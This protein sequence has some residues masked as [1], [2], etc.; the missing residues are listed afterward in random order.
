MSV[1]EINYTLSENGITPSTIQD[2]GIQGDHN[3]KLVIFT[4][5]KSFYEKIKDK[6]YTYY[7]DLYNGEGSNAKTESQKLL[8]N[9]V[10]YS[11]EEWLTRFGGKIAV[12]LV[13]TETINDT[14][15]QEIY[16]YPANFY[17]KNRPLNNEN[18]A[19]KNH[20]QTAGTLLEFVKVAKDS[21]ENA[22]ASEK[23]AKESEEETKRVALTFGENAEWV[24]EGGDAY[25]NIGID[26]VVE[27]T[28]TETKDA[29][30]GK[31]VKTYISDYVRTESEALKKYT[32]EKTKSLNPANYISEEGW[33]TNENFEKLYYEKKNNGIIEM[34]GITKQYTKITFQYS[35]GSL[36]NTQVD[37]VL[38][39]DYLSD[40][41]IW[42]DI[43]PVSGAGLLFCSIMP[44]KENNKLT[45]YFANSVYITDPT[46]IQPQF[47]IRVIGQWKEI[48]T[49]EYN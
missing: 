45:A 18:G 11:I 48:E 21:A 36:F 1:M 10:S 14:T 15:T 47:M 32:D 27:N 8:S 37:I 39:E 20:E 3:A 29:V 17:L 23:A 2:G 4:F 41:P 7:F 5:E 22:K 34:W 24:F 26:F 33:I 46:L 12:Q 31:A 28:V 16:C 25:S 42:A 40:K 49:N 6:E 38:P 30:S 44:S 9:T 13:I 35:Y 43:K 19:I